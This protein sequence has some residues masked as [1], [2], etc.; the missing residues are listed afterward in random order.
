MIYSQ[1]FTCNHIYY[2]LVGRSSS[3]EIRENMQHLLELEGDHSVLP[4]LGCCQ[5]DVID[6]PRWWSFAVELFPVADDHVRKFI[7]DF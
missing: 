4:V 6:V 1:R 2:R 5:C 3:A 7:E